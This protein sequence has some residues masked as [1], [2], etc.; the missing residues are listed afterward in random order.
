M[1]SLINCLE[2]PRLLV[3]VAALAT[4]GLDDIWS[5]QNDGAFIEIYQ[6]VNVIRRLTRCVRISDT[7][8]VSAALGTFLHHHRELEDALVPP[9]T[10]CGRTPRT[11]ASACR[12]STA[13]RLIKD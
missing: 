13:G 6:I 8:L 10:G 12:A 9:A 11:T 5:L 4:Y 1:T 3:A 7:T 2:P